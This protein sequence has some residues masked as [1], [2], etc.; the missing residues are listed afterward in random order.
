MEVKNISS[1]PLLSKGD[2]IKT[3][4]QILGVSPDKLN[5]ILK[6]EYFRANSYNPPYDGKL[7]FYVSGNFGKNYQNV[8]S[9]FV[10][11]Y[12]RGS[13]VFVLDSPF[14]THQSLNLFSDQLSCVTAN[15]P[16]QLL[17]YEFDV[18]S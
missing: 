5:L 14:N 1:D 9:F 8:T 3:A 6:Q 4:S 16:I 7:R 17:Y 12:F 10:S 18:I 13:V 2:L 11:F 15:V